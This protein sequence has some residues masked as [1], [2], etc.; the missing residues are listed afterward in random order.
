[1]SQPGLLPDPDTLNA[2][3]RLA[4]AERSA[5]IAK[6]TRALYARL[7]AR[8]LAEP[9]AAPREWAFGRPTDFSTPPVRS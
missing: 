2:L 4:H 3:I 7:A 6:L 9:P 1:M 8:A 5:A